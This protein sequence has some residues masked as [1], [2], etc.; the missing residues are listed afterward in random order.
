MYFE[1]MGFNNGLNI[2][3]VRNNDASRFAPRRHLFTFHP[4]TRCSDLQEL[5]IILNQGDG[6]YGLLNGTNR[7]PA[8]RRLGA[9]FRKVPRVSSS[10]LM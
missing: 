10:R 9:F 8:T 3:K 7:T 1:L 6:E 2:K 5:F 4:R